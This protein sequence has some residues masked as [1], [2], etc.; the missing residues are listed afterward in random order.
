MN[1][2][3]MEWNYTIPELKKAL[4]E[5]GLPETGNKH[6]MCLRLAGVGVSPAKIVKISPAA[7]KL[8]WELAERYMIPGGGGIQH[9]RVRDLKQVVQ[10]DPY[11]SKHRSEIIDVI[12]R[13]ETIA[14][15]YGEH[16]YVVDLCNYLLVWQETGV[17]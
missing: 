4:R 12:D 15:S 7:I 14:E 10:E 17:K 6:S 1:V 5:A 2:K 3:E 16:A 13:V 8:A 9:V 11:F